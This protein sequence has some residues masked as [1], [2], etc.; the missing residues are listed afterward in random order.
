MGWGYNED[1]EHIIISFDELSRLLSGYIDN[2]KYP[3]EVKIKGKKLLIKKEVL[4]NK[5]EN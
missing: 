5:N 3:L 4:L 2:L 1:K